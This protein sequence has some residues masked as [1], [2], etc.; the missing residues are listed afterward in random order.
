MRNIILS[1]ILSFSCNS[2][3]ASFGNITSEE[4]IELYFPSLNNI[5]RNINEGA[6]SIKVGRE[7][8]NEAGFHRVIAD[9]AQG[10]SVN[11]NMN[12][13]SIH[14]NRPNQDYYQSYRTV[15]SIFA[16]KPLYHW[17]ALQSK[18]RI[19]QLSEEN[20]IRFIESS[21]LSFLIKVK[22]DFMDIVSNKHELDIAKDQ[23]KLYSDNEDSIKKQR[24]LGIVTDLQVDDARIERIKQ[25]ILI[26]E[27]E[28]KLEVGI[29][30]FVFDVGY[31]EHIDFG[32]NKDFELFFLNH[33]FGQKKKLI[34]GQISNERIEDL[35]KQIDTEK[36]NLK[37][38]KAARKPKL[39][40]IGGFFQ[41]QIDLPNSTDPVRRNNFVVGVEANWAIWDS[42]LSKG[43]KELALAKKRKFNLQLEN[44]IR[45]LRL[46]IESLSSQIE[47]LAKQ[48]DASRELLSSS[49]N[50]FEKSK[51][52][53]EAKRITPQTF[54]SSKLS[55]SQ[56]KL[57]LIKT[58]FSY[59]KVKNLYE[60][61]LNYPK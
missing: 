33:K 19:A 2:Y 32:I 60:M 27:L 18:S 5:I 49:I 12:G 61:H 31:D 51:I 21:R 57:I 17:G 16:K 40:L 47:N 44:S 56:A 37:I 7:H 28:R 53:F 39:N 20:S 26:A 52:E 41:D 45:K 23:F 38:A 22:S 6:P 14:E 42:S 58:I 25:S 4:N 3:I 48:I 55:L 1:F 50:R 13:Q 8:V 46:E 24:N 59:L 43:Q 29:S 36:E 34:L 9:S 15:G 10:V 54:L 11:I 35:K 30:N